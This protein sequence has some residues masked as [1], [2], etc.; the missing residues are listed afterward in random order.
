MQE[1]W[2][3]YRDSLSIIQRPWVGFSVRSF[4]PSPGE[5]KGIRLQREQCVPKAQ[6]WRGKFG[7][8]K[9]IYRGLVAAGALEGRVLVL[10]ECRE[11]RRDNT[12]PTRGPVGDELERVFF[13]FWQELGGMGW[14]SSHF[15]PSEVAA[16]EPVRE[17][18]GWTLWLR[19]SMLLP[20]DPK[21]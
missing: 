11:S 4:S 1:D 15:K 6:R 5:G 14:F 3:P 7:D 8:G 17:V 13:F 10:P 19:L 21:G 18:V 16:G 9:L 2:L 12:S 20:K